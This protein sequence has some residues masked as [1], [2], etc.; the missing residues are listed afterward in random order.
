VQVFA[1]DIAELEK[2]GPTAIAAG[3]HDCML[4]IAYPKQTA[5]VPTDLNRDVCW[6]VVGKWGVRPVAQVAV[7][8]IWSALRFRPGEFHRE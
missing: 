5:K 3:K 1:K 7:D 6:R 2:L 4:W 8:D